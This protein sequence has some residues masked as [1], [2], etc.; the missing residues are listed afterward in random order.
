MNSC[1]WNRLVCDVEDYIQPAVTKHTCDNDASRMLSLTDVVA[2]NDLVLPTHLLCD[3]R[4]GQYL[5]SIVTFENA[6][7]GCSLKLVV[8]TEPLYTGQGLTSHGHSQFKG[9]FLFQSLQSRAIVKEGLYRI[10]IILCR[11]HPF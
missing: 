7:F 5:L 11:R 10:Q 9:G 3:V 4:Y 2:G 6:H 1:Y 8:I